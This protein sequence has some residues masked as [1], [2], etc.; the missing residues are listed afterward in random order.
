[1]TASHVKGLFIKPL[2]AVFYW[3][4]GSDE[5]GYYKTLTEMLAD[6]DPDD[7]AEAAKQIKFDADCRNWPLPKTCFRACEVAKAKRLA[8][9][10]PKTNTSVSGDE[11][12]MPRDAAMRI[13]AAQADE[14]AHEASDNDWIVHLVEFV[15]KHKRIP[16]ECKIVDFKAERD[17]ID[18]NIAACQANGGHAND[19]LN[20]WING[21]LEHRALMAEQMK[22]LLA[23]V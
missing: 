1:M 13:L 15:Q 11:T 14:M 21:T 2:M 4:P 16:T 22:E 7:L 23:T 19:I 3:P 8:K 10:R 18:V 9:E 17:R 6:F 12:T 5:D 20:T